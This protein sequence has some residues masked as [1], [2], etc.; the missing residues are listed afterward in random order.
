MIK[1]TCERLMLIGF[2]L[3]LSVGCDQTT[4]RVA[5]QTLKGAAVQSMLHDIIRLQYI[6]N[7]GAFLGFGSHFSEGVK[8][9]LFIIFPVLALIG[10]FFFVLFSQRLMPVQLIM[11]SLIIGGGLGNLIDRVLLEGRVTD[12]M[13]LG[14]GTMR[15]GIFNVAD[16][17]IMI[18][19]FGLFALNLKRP[20]KELQ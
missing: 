9:C 11:I 10:A 17:A 8:V 15:T 1:K 12:F 6:Q 18:G 7:P 3:S 13:N 20:S 14:I 2:V 4:K 5:E 16:V 19:V